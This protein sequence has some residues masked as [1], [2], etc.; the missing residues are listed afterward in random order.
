MAFDV[1]HH[2]DD[3]GDAPELDSW[4]A[5]VGDD[6]IAA[7]VAETRQKI[8]LGH[9]YVLNDMPEFLEWQERTRSKPA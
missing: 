3:Y 8:E 4:R 9:C 1:I 7:I 2:P 6:A 5:E